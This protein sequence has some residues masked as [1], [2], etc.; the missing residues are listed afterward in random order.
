[1]NSMTEILSWDGDPVR[2]V[3]DGLKTSNSRWTGNAWFKPVFK[4]LGS[5]T[6]ILGTFS[7]GLRDI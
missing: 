5:S 4:I 1:M 3:S 2:N 6:C 7:M